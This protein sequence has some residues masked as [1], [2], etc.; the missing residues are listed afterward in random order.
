MLPW[1]R[2]LYLKRHL[3]C[4]SWPSCTDFIDL[5]IVLPFS[6]FLTTWPSC[7][8]TSFN[9]ER[10]WR[11]EKVAK[12]SKDLGPCR[13]VMSNN[14]KSRLEF[15]TPDTVEGI[16]RDF[17]AIKLIHCIDNKTEIEKGELT[18]ATTHV[19]RNERKLGQQ[20]EGVKEERWPDILNPQTLNMHSV[21]ITMSPGTLTRSKLV[22]R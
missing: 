22:N 3:I 11:R 1:L 18:G 4:L 2:P 20:V 15:L 21:L 8:H 7:L 17:L 16:W 13:S 5:Y 19:G 10:A 12:M 14:F 9:Y 6:T